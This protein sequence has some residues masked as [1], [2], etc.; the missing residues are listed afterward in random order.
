MKNKEIQKLELEIKNL[1][2]E[3]DKKRRKLGYGY[4]ELMTGIV[5]HEKKGI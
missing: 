5:E 1:Q 4:E 3:L 2:I